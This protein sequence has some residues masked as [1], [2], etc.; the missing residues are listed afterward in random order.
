[1]NTSLL[2][3]RLLLQVRLGGPDEERACPQNVELSVEIGFASPP[4]AC[5][6]DDVS[7]SVCYDQVSKWL[8]EYAETQSFRTIEKLGFG[9]RALLR[10]HLGHELRVKIH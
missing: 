2:I 6:S 3:R 8:K 4:R 5:F 10:E 7:H 9:C 1:M